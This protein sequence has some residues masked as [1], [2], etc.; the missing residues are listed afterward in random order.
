M[1]RFGFRCE[2]VGAMRYRE[3]R[4]SAHGSKERNQ[5]IQ[6]RAKGHLS[7]ISPMGIATRPFGSQTAAW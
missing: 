7:A 2:C 1:K 5:L 6:F 3:A 4:Q